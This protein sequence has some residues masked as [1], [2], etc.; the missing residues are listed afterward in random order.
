VILA[1]TSVWIDHFR[2]GRSKLASLLDRDEVLMH[3]FVVG[4]LAC[5]NLLARETTIELLEQMRAI[6]VADHAEVMAF[7][8]RQ[9]LHGRGVGYIDVHLLASA[10]I[11]GARLWTR[12]QGL[13][14]LAYKLDL[15][16]PHD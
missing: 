5:G 8:Q 10:A 16:V 14:A 13:R 9:R 2:G 15:A 11:D 1:D 7:I 6:T 4:E 12:D 3:P